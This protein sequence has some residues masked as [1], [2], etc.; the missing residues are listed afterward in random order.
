MS[1]LFPKNS[2]DIQYNVVFDKA[3]ILEEVKEKLPEPWMWYTIKNAIVNEPAYDLIIIRNRE[4]K[5][6]IS[7]HRPFSSFRNIVDS[8]Y[9]IVLGVNIVDR[10]S[11]QRTFDTALEDP[12]VT[13]AIEVNSARTLF[14]II[15]DF[16]GRNRGIKNDG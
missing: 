9:S 7:H 12:I 10:F 6:E 11:S 16:D 15:K 13:A 2:N 14:D 4:V 3:D 1:L 5:E 8:L